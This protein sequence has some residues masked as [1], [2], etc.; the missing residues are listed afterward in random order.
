M[1]RNRKTGRVPTNTMPA[2]KKK[3]KVII[4]KRDT[5]LKALEKTIAI[6]YDDLENTVTVRKTKLEKDLQSITFTVDGSSVQVLFGAFERD[7]DPKYWPV[8]VKS[9]DKILNYTW[10]GK[11]EVKA[12]DVKTEYK[13]IEAAKSGSTFS[14]VVSYSFIK[15]ATANAYDK[16]ILS[17]Q[18]SDTA[19]GNSLL[20][21]PVNLIVGTVFAT[22]QVSGNTP[23]AVV[24][25]TPAP[26]DEPVADAIEE[27][28]AQDDTDD[29][30]PIVSSNPFMEWD[31][32]TPTLDD[33]KFTFNIQQKEIEGE[34]CTGLSI[35]GKMS[36]KNYP[37]FAFG[38]YDNPDVGKILQKGDNLKFKV[39]GDGKTYKVGLHLADDV[40]Y[41]YVFTTKKDTVMEIKIP[42]SKLVRGSWCKKT[43]KFSKDLLDGIVFGT[44]DAKSNETRVIY[45]YDIVAY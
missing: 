20:T 31:S 24:K 32:W 38:I 42:Y 28:P 33:G 21:V 6:K 27:E 14:G 25:E 45:I 36:S 35:V 40:E 8:S 2:S 10:N 7:T 26:Q 30:T 18:V 12:A 17:I 44:Q 13:L 23:K 41:E 11:Y 16:K 15:S 3:T 29:S 19:T 39:L 1:P 43:T 34:S 22:V 9:L 37:W 5:E 4:Q